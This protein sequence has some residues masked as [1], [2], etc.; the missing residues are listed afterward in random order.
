MLPHHLT[1]L[2]L[3]CFFSSIGFSNVRFSST[4]WIIHHPSAL[5][6][7]V[8]QNFSEK[9]EKT[10]QDLKRL[11]F[12]AITTSGELIKTPSQSFLVLEADECTDQIFTEAY[13]EQSSLSI[14]TSLLSIGFCQK[15][16]AS[17]LLQTSTTLTVGCLVARGV[18][19]LALPFMK[20]RYLPHRILIHRATYTPDPENLSLTYG[21]SIEIPDVLRLYEERHDHMDTIQ[22]RMNI[23]NNCNLFATVAAFL[24]IPHITPWLQR[25]YSFF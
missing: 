14:M 13:N 5:P 15:N 2:I 18:N 17:M 22:D 3:S 19:I 6:E 23:L 16:L 21:S 4:P 7:Q 10:R 12:E 9:I 24:T 1:T 11:G 25:L 20:K 8:S